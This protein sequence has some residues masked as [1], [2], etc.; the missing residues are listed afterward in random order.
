VIEV[1]VP[2]DARPGDPACWAS[3]GGA[4]LAVH[5]RSNGRLAIPGWAMSPALA[6]RIEAAIAQAATA[7]DDH[8]RIESADELTA[9][10]AGRQA[11]QSIAQDY[12]RRARMAAAR[13][14]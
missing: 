3:I 5:R 6:G 8:C 12:E 14:P 13:W 2:R 10:R 9:R 7:P 4:W 1:V 11:E